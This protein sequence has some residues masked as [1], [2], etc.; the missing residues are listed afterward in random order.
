MPP[1]VKKS[2][3]AFGSDI[4]CGMKKFICGPGA[5]FTTSGIGNAEPLVLP[6]G[7]KTST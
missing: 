2:T 4:G 6:L 3:G 5:E 7:L 1:G